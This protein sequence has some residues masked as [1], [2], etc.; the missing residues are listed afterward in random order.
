MKALK[1]TAVLATATETGVARAFGTLAEAAVAY[2]MDKST[3]SR[4]MAEGR[5]CRGVRFERKG[6]VILARKDGM[7]MLT[8]VRDGELVG[9]DGKVVHPDA[10]LDITADFYAGGGMSETWAMESD[11][12][13]I[14]KRLAAIEEKIDGLC[15]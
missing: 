1:T 6:R 8:V 3:V 11:M 2:G 12:G 13:E 14:A 4:A 15:R 5:V 7:Y 9:K 10:V